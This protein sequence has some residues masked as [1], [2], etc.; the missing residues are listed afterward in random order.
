[1]P[2]ESS[3]R[4][5][6][7]FAAAGVAF[8]APCAN[9]HAWDT[10]FEFSPT[11]MA[12]TPPSAGD[13]ASGARATG[14]APAEAEVETGVD[15]SK[16]LFRFE[17]NPQYTDLPGDGSL[18]TTNLKLDMPITRSVAVAI[19]APIAY[20]SGF[21]A[22]LEEEFGFGD[23][24]VRV[25]HVWSFEKTS[26]IAGAEIVLDTATDD[27]LGG[28]KWQVNPSVALVFHLSEEYLLAT[29]WKQRISVAGDDD[30]ADLDASE[31]RLIGIYINPEGWWLQADY[32]PKLD[33]ESG[34]ELSH[35]MEFEVGTMI[36][37]SVG[38][39]VRPGFG[40]GA[41]KERDWSIGVGLR[42][43]F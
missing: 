39:S 6:T 40:F 20:A 8:A 16:L 38:V 35:L 26:L 33:W 28:G 21:P 19:D 41:N 12:L 14:A 15:P 18:F 27:L 29:A 11:T 32:Q 2:S 5:G 30:R 43:L 25:R 23:V 36:S 1:M 9:A 37:R 22:P 3:N 42:F 17:C 7:V 24:A 34:G 13:G 10:R 4:I 31:F